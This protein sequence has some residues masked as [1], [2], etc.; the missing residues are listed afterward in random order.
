MLIT[1]KNITKAFVIALD[2]F[3][4]SEARVDDN[5]AAKYLAGAFGGVPDL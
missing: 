2:D 3:P 4:S 5:I 1:E